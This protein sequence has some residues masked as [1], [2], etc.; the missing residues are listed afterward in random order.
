M[1]RRIKRP[2]SDELMRFHRREQMRKLSLILRS[3]LTFKHVDS[4]KILPD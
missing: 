2:V 4:F 3:I 1:V